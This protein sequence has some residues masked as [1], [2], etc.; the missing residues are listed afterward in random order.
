VLEALVVEV[1]KNLDREGPGVIKLH[2]LVTIE[3]KRFPARSAQRNVP[4]PFKPGEVRD[5]AA[6]PAYS[7]IKVRTLTLRRDIS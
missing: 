5:F 3:I 6:K 4:N 2:D 1:K 7:K